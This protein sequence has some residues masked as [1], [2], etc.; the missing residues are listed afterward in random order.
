MLA[1]FKEVINPAVILNIVTGDKLLTLKENSS[2]SKIKKLHIKDVPENAFAFTLD[3]QPSG[4][5]RRWF[6]QLS[7]YVNIGNDKGV[8]KGCDLI[9]LVPEK[10]NNCKVLIFDIKSDKPRIKDTKKQLIN[11]ELYVRYLMSMVHSHYDVNIKNVKFQR[12]IVTTDKNSL[13]KTSTYRPNQKTPKEKC[14]STVSVNVTA[15]KDAYV[16]LGVL[17]R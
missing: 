8:N 5:D 16:H 3:H 4:K 15:H 11:S 17:L 14:F 7:C 6:K 13:R 9:L 2:E 1:A 10:N 12:T